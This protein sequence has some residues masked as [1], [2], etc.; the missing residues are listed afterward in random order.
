MSTTAEGTAATETQETQPK[1]EEHVHGEN[2]SHDHGH[3]HEHHEDAKSDSDSDDGN[4][5]PNKKS[6]R[7]EKKFKKAMVKLGLKPLT[8]I[9]RVTVKKG[10]DVRICLFSS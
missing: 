1:I 6:S 2:C 3:D 5:D 8:G 9:N 4:T 10:K 7:A